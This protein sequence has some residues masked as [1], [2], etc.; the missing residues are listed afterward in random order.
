MSSDTGSTPRQARY[1]VTA[2]RQQGF[3]FTEVLVAMLILGISVMAFAGLQVRALQTTG[4]SHTR[5]V[6]M[7]LAGDLSER[8]RA[9]PDGAATY[10]DSTKY[11]GAV[12][13]DSPAEWGSSSCIATNTAANGC[14]AVQMAEF[15]INEIEY[16]AGRLL[17]QG[18]V[19]VLPCVGATDMTCVYLAWGGTAASDCDSNASTNCVAMEVLTQ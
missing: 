18:S 7:S 12:P 17:P 19:R 2:K 8:M 5:S 11:N 4:T 13:D 16:Q 1:D 14:T 3:T 10:R 15:D 6:A 9:N